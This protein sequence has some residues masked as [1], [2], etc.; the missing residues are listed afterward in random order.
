M[1]RIDGAGRLRFLGREDDQVKIRGFRI[2]LD[3]ISSFLDAQ[4][5]VKNSVVTVTDGDSLDKKIVAAVQLRPGTDITPADLS[6]RLRDHLPSYM[7]PTL[8]ALIDQLPVT[9]NGKID[10]RRL[11]AVAKPASSFAKRRQ[12]R[13]E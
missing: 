6:D 13:S 10:R 3:A 4:E 8:W 11:A 12:A 5:G 9:P 2:E 1:V 7:V